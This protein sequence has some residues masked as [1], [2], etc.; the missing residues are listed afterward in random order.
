[1]KWNSFAILC[2]LAIAIFVFAQHKPAQSQQGNSAV[3][4]LTHTLNDK[5]PA[6]EYEAVAPM[7]VEPAASYEQNGYMA[8]T[9]TVPEQGGTHVDAPAYFI[10]GRWTTDQIPSER[11]VRPLAVIDVTAKVK[12][13][14]DYRVSL[15]DVAAWE[16]SHGHIA[17]GAVVMARTGWD[18]RWDSSREYRNVDA[19]GQPHFP[20]FS[21]EAARFLVEARQAVGL[22]IDTMS[23]DGGGT[24]DFVIHRY[25][26]SRSV[27]QVEN[28][29]NLWQAP[30]AGATV[31]VAPAKI[32]GSAGAPARVMAMVQG[33]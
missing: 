3:I 13:N 27:Y 12:Q 8:R 18:S 2:S 29:A 24:K 26:E 6:N 9:V 23:V 7:R 25:C 17:L 14:P 19:G 20:G 30:E 16:K 22:G 4:D 1:M 28:V 21:L 32:E 10:K 11:L 33:Q 31:V 15:E 5:A